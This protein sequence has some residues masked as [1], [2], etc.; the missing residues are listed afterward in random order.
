[1]ITA[2]KGGE[3]PEPE[4]GTTELVVRAVETTGRPALVSLEIPLLGRTIDATFGPHQIRTWRL[5]RD[6]DVPP[7]EIDL[8]ERELRPGHIPNIPSQS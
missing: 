7:V 8:V 1:M 4:D 5:P 3:D 2:I 6:R